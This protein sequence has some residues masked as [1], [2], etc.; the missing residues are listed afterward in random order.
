MALL[1]G[2]VSAC[3][4]ESAEPGS[5][6]SSGGSSSASPSPSASSTNG[7]GMAKPSVDLADPGE[8]LLDEP[9]NGVVLEGSATH[10]SWR[11]PAEC[12]ESSRAQTAECEQGDASFALIVGGKPGLA[13]AEA[14]DAEV[15]RA[16][17][18]QGETDQGEVTVAGRGFTAVTYDAGA[19]ETSVTTFLHQPDGSPDTFAV[20]FPTEVPPGE[21]PQQRVDEVY[22]LLG[23]LEFEPAED[24]GP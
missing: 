11:W 24:A 14:V 23:S 21:V 16:E 4:E 19:N 3:G 18:G 10:I 5:A 7:E 15:E 8:N 22:Q 20:V 1:V 2:G 9:R 12:Y 17:A 6:S 13:L